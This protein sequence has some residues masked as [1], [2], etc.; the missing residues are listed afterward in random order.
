MFEH[1][2]IGTQWKPLHPGPYDHAV[3]IPLPETG[4]GVTLTKMTSFFAERDLKMLEETPR[5]RSPKY[6]KFITYGFPDEQTAKDFVALF[7]GEY[8][9]P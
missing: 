3:K 2:L 7:G 8:I 5:R 6:L 1:L 9:R 4:L